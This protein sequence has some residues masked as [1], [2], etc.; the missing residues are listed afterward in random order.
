MDNYPILKDARVQT[1]LGDKPSIKLEIK[2]MLNRGI[3]GN[4]E[5]IKLGR[6]DILKTILKKEGFD[7]SCVS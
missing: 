4:P 7:V 2:L 1:F 6:L 5:Q 3:R